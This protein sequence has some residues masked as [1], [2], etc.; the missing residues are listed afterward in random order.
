MYSRRFGEQRLLNSRFSYSVSFTESK[1]HSQN[2][3]SV[4]EKF[5]NI[6]F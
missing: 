1:N 2:S 4:Q 5:W 6:L 3:L